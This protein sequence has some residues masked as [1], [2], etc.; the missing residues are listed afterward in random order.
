MNTS[1][2]LVAFW[3]FNATIL[4]HSVK[5]V[6]T[7]A[8]AAEQSLVRLVIHTDY[9]DVLPTFRTGKLRIHFRLRQALKDQLQLDVIGVTL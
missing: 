2:A 7:D 9:T 4:S 3:A 6:F 8:M 5:T 1:P